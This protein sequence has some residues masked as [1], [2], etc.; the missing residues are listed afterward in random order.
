[1][2]EK[3]ILCEMLI[4]I[5]TMKFDFEFLLMFAWKATAQTGVM[6]TSVSFLE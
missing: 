6:E 3:I 1:M 5:E 4:N 2:S